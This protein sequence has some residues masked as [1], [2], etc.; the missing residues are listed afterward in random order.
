M[1]Q[2]LKKLKH[3]S[4]I[5]TFARTSIVLPA[6]MKCLAVN[7][8]RRSRRDS[9]KTVRQTQRTQTWTDKNHLRQVWYLPKVI[10]N[11]SD[12][13]SKFSNLSNWKEEAWKKS[14]LQRDSNP[15]EAL[16]F[17]VRLLLSNCLNWK[18]YCDDHSSLSSITAVQI[19]IISYQLHSY[20]KCRHIINRPQLCNNLEK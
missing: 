16:I 12:H 7:E 1:I 6:L 9:I 15:V 13:R 18:I 19:W 10:W 8:Y 11:E 2:L 4:T 5:P 20:L 17:F 14:G 3:K